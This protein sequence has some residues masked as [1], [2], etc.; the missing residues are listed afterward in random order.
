MIY[1]FDSSRIGTL[2]SFLKKIRKS[3]LIVISI[4][5]AFGGAAQYWSG[6]DHGELEVP[7]VV[8]IGTASP[9][10]AYE[11]IGEGLAEILNEELGVRHITAVRTNGS[12]ENLDLL[13]AGNLELALVQSDG[14]VREDVMT[15]AKLYD[16]I[17]HIIVKSDHFDEPPK[18]LM[19]LKGRRLAIG[20]KKSGTRVAVKE[21]LKYYSINFTDSVIEDELPS[22]EAAQISFEKG[23]I[24]AI[25]IISGRPCKTVERL[26]KRK[27][28]VLIPVESPERDAPPLKKYVKDK[29]VGYKLMNLERGDYKWGPRKNIPTIATSALLVAR[30][31]L[32]PAFIKEVTRILF[33][34]RSEL[35]RKYHIAAKAIVRQK[36]NEDELPY[37]TH[38]GAKLFYDNKTTSFLS[39]NGRW[40]GMT[41][42]VLAYLLA[43][44]VGVRE[45]FRVRR[46]R[47][48]RERPSRPSATAVHQHDVFIV[49]SSRSQTSVKAVDKI[50]EALESNEISYWYAPKKMKAG[51]DWAGTIPDAIRSTRY[52]IILVFS[53]SA[54]R[55][56]HCQR[57]ISLASEANLRIIP[58]FVEN[59]KPTGRI[60]YH[61][62][63]LHRIEAFVGSQEPHL[64]ELIKSIFML[65]SELGSKGENSQVDDRP[66]GMEVT[67]PH[68]DGRNKKG[69]RHLL[70]SLSVFLGLLLLLGTIIWYFSIEYT[71]PDAPIATSPIEGTL[72][73][74]GPL[75]Y[76]WDFPKHRT[77]VKYDIE[78]WKSNGA[79][80]H[81]HVASESWTESERRLSGLVY[82]RVRALIPGLDGHFEPTQ[83]SQDNS[84]RYYMNTLEKIRE[85]GRVVVAVSDDSCN[86]IDANGDDTNLEIEW[87]RFVLQKYLNQRGQRKELELVRRVKPWGEGPDE[88]FRSLE[89]P[90]VDLMA[91]AITIKTERERNWKVKFTKPIVIYHQ[92]LLHYKRKSIC[93]GKGRSTGS[94]KIGVKVKTTNE[95]LAQALAEQGPGVH[96]VRFFQS[97]NVYN[98]MYKALCD[99]EIDMLLMDEPFAVS[100]QQDAKRLGTKFQLTLVDE[101]VMDKPPVEEI[102]IALKRKDDVL[103]D[104][105]NNAIAQYGDEI[106]RLKRTLQHKK[107]VDF[108]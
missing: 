34:N 76:K 72:Q 73:I 87:I 55:S 59:E 85:T 35:S 56:E 17:L 45:L 88:L 79:K 63:H 95:E 44:V 108:Q 74:G 84:Y 62:A 47:R 97:D 57:E 92:A 21:L 54:N 4:L 104:V 9:G 69:W 91:S 27:D 42:A 29:S 48:L 8:R 96:V 65:K 70:I 19:D 22:T 61:T 100:I 13:G 106:E 52:A 67:L 49:Y 15:V 3:I 51:V 24:D 12:I 53:K 14:P 90:E 105:I 46:T 94:C 75:N 1:C 37:K 68:T 78:R 32:K 20:P 41:I 33:G 50:R 38:L 82:W 89:S 40:I 26:L 103:C 93:A 7:S 11:R 107:A 80:Y 58:Y 25:F 28:T 36:P 71:L 66:L 6:S 43:V 16:E 10:G 86:Y 2:G 5:L 99:G 101:E 23:N 102:G 81:K 18:S 77:G 83:W 31:D 30:Y 60:L 64:I 98:I 39:R